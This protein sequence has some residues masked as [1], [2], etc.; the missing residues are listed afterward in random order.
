MHLK[1]FDAE[2]N[3]RKNTAKMSLGCSASAENSKSNYTKTQMFVYALKEENHI[4]VLHI[5]FVRQYVLTFKT[6]IW[7]LDCRNCVFYI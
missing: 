7:I 2:L 3:P 5:D 6:W 4:I 1:P